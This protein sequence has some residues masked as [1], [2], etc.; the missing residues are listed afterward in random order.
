VKYAYHT[1]LL[2]HIS[3]TLRSGFSATHSHSL[4]SFPLVL[5]G[6]ATVRLS[7]QCTILSLHTRLQETQTAPVQSLLDLTLVSVGRLACRE[8]RD[9]FADDYTRLL[10]DLHGHPVSH[11]PRLFHPHKLDLFPHLLHARPR[12]WSPRWRIPQCC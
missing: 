11:L 7:S 6:L 5:S 2:R 1:L 3:L 12:L 8:S 9:K 4:S 10:H